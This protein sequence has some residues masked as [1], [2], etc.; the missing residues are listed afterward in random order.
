MFLGKNGPT[1]TSQKNKINGKLTAQLP[2]PAEK[3][4]GTTPMKNHAKGK[5]GNPFHAQVKAGLA[6]AFPSSKGGY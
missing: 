1:A 4:R 5:K 6:K 2:S 3:K